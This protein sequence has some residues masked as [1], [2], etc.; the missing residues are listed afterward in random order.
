MVGTMRG[1]QGRGARGILQV[2]RDFQALE[3][4]EVAVRGLT[5]SEMARFHWS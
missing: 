1:K 4:R 3:E 2:E 5:L